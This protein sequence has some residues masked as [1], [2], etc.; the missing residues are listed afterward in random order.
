MTATQRT[1]LTL[2]NILNAANEHYDES[3]LSAYFD[4]TTGEPIAR[5]G[6]TLAEFIVR[7][8]RETFEEQSSRERQVAT[9]VRVLDRAKD[10]IENA[11]VGLEELKSAG[12][13]STSR[14]RAPRQGLVH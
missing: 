4:A 7:E 13:A 12:S 1:K 2:M 5:S 9:A 10:C 3:Y 11:I 6:D 14:S 8:L